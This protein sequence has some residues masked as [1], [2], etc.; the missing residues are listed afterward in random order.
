[1]GPGF[2]AWHGRRVEDANAAVGQVPPPQPFPRLVAQARQP[3]EA[4]D[5]L[6]AVAAAPVIAAIAMERRG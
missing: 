3:G 6:T 2:F 1:M 5:P 4:L